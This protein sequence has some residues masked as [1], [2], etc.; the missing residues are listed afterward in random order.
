LGY[1]DEEKVE[2]DFEKIAG[3]YN[4]YYDKIRKQCNECYITENCKQCIFY[5]D[6]DSEKPVCK[7][8]MNETDFS[9]Y[10]AARMSYLEE[11]PELYSIS[12]KNV[13]V[14]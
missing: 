2:I 7:G 10:L 8:C 13:S 11:R 6:I 3:K 9:N 5:L 1:V 4:R 14:T 12:M